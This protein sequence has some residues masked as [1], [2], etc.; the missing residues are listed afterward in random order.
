MEREMGDTPARL[1]GDAARLMG[2]A[3]RLMGEAAK[4]RMGGTATRFM[5]PASLNRE[6]AALGEDDLG[7][8]DLWLFAP[9]LVVAA[10]LPLAIVAILSASVYFASHSAGRYD[11]ASFA[12][13]F[14]NVYTR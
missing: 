5:R 10:A 6:L 11:G 4:R 8:R 9:L 3:A 7:K 13:R 2:Q 14:E 12:S 1:M